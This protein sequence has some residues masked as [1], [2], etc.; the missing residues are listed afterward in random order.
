MKD[1]PA[2]AMNQQDDDGLEERGREVTN[3]RRHPD[4]GGNEQRR[5]HRF[6]GEAQNECGHGDR[7][8]IAAPFRPA[9]CGSIDTL[10]AHPKLPAKHGTVLASSTPMRL[11]EIAVWSVGAGVMLAIIFA[12]GQ[13][14]GLTRLGIPFILGT[15]FTSDRD[16]AKLVGHGLNLVAAIAFGAIYVLFFE[17]HGHSGLL[18]GAGLG[19]SFTACSS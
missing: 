6:G 10:A 8:E 4:F 12:C 16:R 7:E 2:A 17:I 5:S 13:A 11:M 18:Y 1:H 3:A 14:L 19:G 15:M 9:L